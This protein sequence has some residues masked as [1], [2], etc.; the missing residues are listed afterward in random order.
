MYPPARCSART[1]GF[2]SVRLFFRVL[3][4]CPR[5]GSAIA[6]LIAAGS[7]FGSDC[8]PNAAY[9]SEFGSFNRL[10]SAAAERSAFSKTEPKIRVLVETELLVLPFYTASKRDVFEECSAGHA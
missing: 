6:G 8:V 4:F 1:F 10:G 7:G 3:R 2:S 9:G 5:S